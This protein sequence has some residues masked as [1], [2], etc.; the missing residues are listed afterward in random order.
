MESFY[1][2]IIIF[3][4]FFLNGVRAES[5]LVTAGAGGL[6]V[7]MG[8][9]G[10]DEKVLEL[11]VMAAQPGDTLKTTESRVLKRWILGYVN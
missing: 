10:G 4:N 7:A 8:F 9:L 2:G 11:V 5:G 1:K 6:G 3:P